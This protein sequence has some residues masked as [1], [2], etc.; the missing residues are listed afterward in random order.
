MEKQENYNASSFD[1]LIR[2]INETAQDVQR[3][4]GTLFERLVLAYLKNEPTYKN[5]YKNVW[6]LKDV[7]SEFSISK[8]DLGVDL[9]AEQQNG[10]LVAIQA[11]FNKGKIGKSEINSF[12]AELG[13]T[14][15][16]RGLIISTVDEWNSN[17]RATIDKN[18]KGIEII[19]LS[20]LR[21]SQINWADFSFERPEQTTIK[22]PKSLRPYQLDA[23]ESAVSYFKT[24]D[25]GQLIMAPGTGKTFTSLKI[26]EALSKQ[27]D[28]QFKVL[29]LVPSIQLLTQTLRGWNND[30]EYTMT[31]MAVTS[32]RDASRGDDGTE[33]I[34]ATDI[35]YPA[36]TS[37][38]QLLKNWND[39]QE[40]ESNT[41][42]FVVFSTYQSI[43][44]IGKA[45]KEGFPEFDLIISDEAHRTTGAHEMNKDA[46]VF[47]KVHDNENV[48]GKLRMYQTATPKIYGEKA[49]KSAK[50]KSYL[51]S[52]M[53][54]ESKY[55]EVIYRMGF[56]QAVS[57]GILTDYKVMV[58]A[59]DE[60]AIQR[61]MQRTLADP[62]NGL[63]IDDVGRIVGIWNGMMRRNGYKNPIK[64]SPY[65]GAPLERAIAFTRT[66]EDSK[67]V[68]HQFEEV[69]NEYIGADIEEQSKK[70][71]MR[72]ADGTMNALQ[73]GEVLDWLADSNKPSDEARI[74]SNVRFL[75]EGID[76]PTLDAVIFL[77][78]KKS[79]VDI[80]QAVGRIMRKSENKDYGY[81]ILPIVIPAGEKPETILDNNKNY[82]AVWQIINALRSV[83][84]RFEAMVDKLNIA[85]PKQL[86]VIGVGPSPD[87]E[88]DLVNDNAETNQP[89]PKEF[90]PTQL[91]FQWDKYE[92]AIFGKIVEKVGNRKYLENWSADV[93]KIAQRQISWIKTKLEDKNDPISI[94]FKKFVSS[95]QHNINESIDE[96]QAADMLSQHL[97][98]KPIFEAL[99]S[100]YSFVNNNPVSSAM[101]NIV[102]E[103]ERAG[104]AKEQ[105]NLAPLYESVK[106]RAEGVEKAEDKQ[107]IIITL[108]D[109]FFSTAF[110]STTERLGIVFTPIEVVDFIVKSVDDVLKK[111]FGKKLSSED[112]HILDP[113]TGTGTFIV[114]T[115]EYLKEQMETGEISLADITRKFTQELHANEIVL[116]SYYI[117]AINIEATFDE[118]NGDEQGYIPFEGIVLTDT[119]ESTENDNTLIDEYFNGNDERLKRQLKENITVIIGNP[120]YSTGQT[121][122]ND[123]LKN[124][125][126]CQLEQ[127][128]NETYANSSKAGLKQSLYDSYIKA[129]RWSS[130]RLNNKG[131][132]GFVTNGQYI[133]SRSADG[134]RK[135]LNDEFNYLY[136]FNL[137]G[138][139]R[140]QGEISRKEGG[141]I[142]G[143]GSRTPISISIMVKD[144][145][146][147]HK[148]YYHDIGDYLKREEK[149]EIIRERK[150][151]MNIKWETILPDDNNDWINQ[152][153]DEYSKFLAMDS[154]IFKDR[155]IGISTNRDSW[156]Y[157]FSKD[158]SRENTLKMIRN[159]N[160]EVERLMGLDKLSKLEVLNT[161]PSYI[162]WTDRLKNDLV[163]ERKITLD[164]EKLRVSM[165]RPF[166]K[167]WLF[168]DNKV[169]H[170]PRK[171]ES[172]LEQPNSIIFTS[173]AGAK[174]EFSA[175]AVNVIPNQ[176]MNEK[177][178]GFYLF[179][180]NTTAVQQDK[181]NIRCQFGLSEEETFYYIYAVLH[182][183][184]YLNKYQNDLQ[185]SL[186]QIPNLKN[187]GIYVNVGK[188]LYNLHLNY[189]NQEIWP[190]VELVYPN[191]KVDYYV[192]KMKH[193]KGQKNI[194]IYN[195][196]ITIKNI[197]LKAYEYIVNGKSAIEWIMDQ[198]QLKTDKKTGITDDP[199]LYSD[200]PK[201][202]L[203]LILSIITVSMK[204]LELVEQLPKFE[205]E[206]NIENY[207]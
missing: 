54:D 155:S 158:S 200:N 192:E 43:E 142:F 106:M 184:E 105:E 11:K 76:V 205:L 138:D 75:T 34:K 206:S 128:I 191:K 177:G 59:V 85:K 7:P 111:H 172:I 32:D 94:E 202:I 109:K 78:P 151:I 33:D 91:E 189:E 50:E 122:E 24:K 143:S 107:K 98:T 45:Q 181:Y 12:V 20:D 154:D 81:I 80:V 124:I 31:S 97:I 127:R 204:T 182:S 90:E 36:T 72:H 99:F 4:R 46:S 53:D 161:D 66:I 42:L 198:Y 13:S 58:L 6:L 144:G 38:D 117:A 166:T 77:A 136:I 193:Q 131:I 22:Q 104:F 51:L 1:N 203:N 68:S 116:L 147:D 9:V 69:V 17:A 183:P 60:T 130:D 190:E 186:P 112:V 41:D 61:D 35:G 15:Y 196:E 65:D 141:K 194:I 146:N 132:I 113:F 173:G 19:G 156:V 101:E 185:K 108:Y 188:E 74:V 133:D 44:V 118:I 23:L 140:T 95:L 126:Y 148:V 10:D 174:R 135:S 176:D 134:L 40:K 71:S 47:T 8:K 165:Y 87:K 163:A 197:P 70:L 28:K 195:N 64:N 180:S 27:S 30:T 93:A 167:K 62:E 123:N 89:K 179:N 162:K 79:Q 152:R 114:R 160:N 171:Y 5:L 67:K 137:R 103:L 170:R 92:Q 88:N 129:I 84:E 100:E 164:E 125:K 178:Q 39:V 149:L 153:N 73:K 14:Y 157:S 115:L 139:Q 150:S 18:E 26:A 207:L 2:Q 187:K 199:N 120:P 110:K 169:I 119:F 29:Y 56:G 83:D 96:N 52:S 102:Q 82:E 25:R 121:N 63:N 21:N 168:F 175:I 16:T 3:E 49:Q 201:Y 55:G 145:S 37:K 57:R 48:K 159:Y 86:R